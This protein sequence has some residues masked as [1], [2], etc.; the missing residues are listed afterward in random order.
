MS[1]EELMIVGRVASWW[2]CEDV[3]LTMSKRA[4]AAWTRAVITTQSKFGDHYAF[5]HG[6]RDNWTASVLVI[7]G[8]KEKFEEIAGVELI[9]PLQVHA[10]AREALAEGSGEKQND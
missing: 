5:G 6:S 8:L 1:E 2:R 9:A 10:N 3:R 4:L 7:D